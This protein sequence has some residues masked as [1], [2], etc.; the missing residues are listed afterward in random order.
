MK[1]TKLMAIVAILTATL[2]FTACND[3][4]GDSNR[5]YFSNVVTYEG[6]SGGYVNFSFQEMNDAQPIIIR[7]QGQMPADVTIGRRVFISFSSTATNLTDGMV[8]SLTQC[9]AIPNVKASINEPV[10]SDWKDI[11]MI[12]LQ[13]IFR[14]GNWINLA[15]LVP[16]NPD[17]TVTPKLIFDPA[18]IDAEYPEAYMIFEGLNPEMGAVNNATY[19]ATYDIADVWGLPGCRG[20]KIHV[21]NTNNSVNGGSS[22][23]CEVSEGG[24]LITIKK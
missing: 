10:P 1:L 16:N 18:T 17:K 6:N 3:N 20:I 14:S 12:Y 15:A 2:G 8:V 19:I 9:V 4:G 7:A 11:S 13:T 5:L 21:N 22:Q 24:E 23:S